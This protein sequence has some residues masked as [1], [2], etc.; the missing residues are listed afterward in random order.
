M[1]DRDD[2][3]R[4]DRRGSGIGRGIGR[5]R[6]GKV[7][8]VGGHRV[9]SGGVSGGIREEQCDGEGEIVGT[10]RGEGELGTGRWRG[11]RVRGAR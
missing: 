9:E 10:G 5:G 1:I 3:E 4:L 8:D 2:G 11:M 7:G 6:S